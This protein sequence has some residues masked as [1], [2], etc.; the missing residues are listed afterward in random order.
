[1]FLESNVWESVDVQD[2]T[3]SIS[4]DGVFEPLF[5]PWAADGLEVFGWLDFSLD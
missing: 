5:A 3:S 4:T 2:S 1:M